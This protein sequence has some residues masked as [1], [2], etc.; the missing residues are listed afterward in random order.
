M[1]NKVY[2]ICS[3]LF[4][5]FIGFSY[6]VPNSHISDKMR[7][8]ETKWQAELIRDSHDNGFF[9]LVYFEYNYIACFLCL[10]LLFIFGRTIFYDKF[11]NFFY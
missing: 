3:I 1:K 5:V 4:S 11:M 8:Q 9:S 2:V 6:K 7:R 10:C